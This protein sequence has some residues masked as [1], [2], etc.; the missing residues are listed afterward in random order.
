MPVCRLCCCE[1][2][3]DQLV[4]CSDCSEGHVICELCL[5]ACV[6]LDCRDGAEGFS[7]RVSCPFTRTEECVSE[8]YG[9]ALLARHVPPATFALYM[10]ARER[11]AAQRIWARA[12]HELEIARQDFERREQAGA[13]TMLASALQAQFPNARQCARCSFGPVTHYACADLRAHHQERTAVGARV[14]NACPLCGWFVT[15]IDEWPLW[16]GTVRDGQQLRWECT[17]C[18][19]H[20]DLTDFECAACAS[21][22]GAELRLVNASGRDR[23]G[24]GEEDGVGSRRHVQQHQQPVQAVPDE[25]PD[26]GER[27]LRASEQQ[28]ALRRLRPPQLSPAQPAEQAAGRP[29]WL[30][31]SAVLPGMRLPNGLGVPF[32]FLLL[33]LAVSVPYAIHLAA[34]GGH[35]EPA[36]FAAATRLDSA[37]AAAPVLCVDDHEPALAARRSGLASA[38][39]GATI[40]MRWLF[41]TVLRVLGLAFGLLG[42]RAQAAI[43]CAAACAAL[44]A[45]HRIVRSAL[46]MWA[47]LTADHAF[48]TWSGCYDARRLQEYAIKQRARMYLRVPSR[49]RSSVSSGTPSFPAHDIQYLEQLSSDTVRQVRWHYYD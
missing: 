36:P 18:S 4:R 1:A 15:S 47:W 32:A 26:E 9:D 16:D 40:A 21:V 34:S 44:V 12:Q 30:C 38:A 17:A 7:G 23:A 39:A 5:A 25:G 43:G 14:D 24:D 29:R 10:R 49:G 6:E 41:T 11:V 20:N 27:L 33:A 37:P 45:L 28:R 42:F 3:D 19:L 35:R 31:T 2:D 13:S 46:V 8:P 48:E 22:R